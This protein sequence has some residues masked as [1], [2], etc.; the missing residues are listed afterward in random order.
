M[1]S[2][3]ARTFAALWRRARWVA[4]LA[5]LACGG[6]VGVAVA[7][8]PNASFTFSPSSPLT[9]EA[10][11]FDSN[12]TPDSSSRP[13]VREEWDLDNDGAFDDR[14]VC[15]PSAPNC[16]PT[17]GAAGAAIG[18]P[19]QHSYATPGSRTVR[20]RVIDSAGDDDTSSR[21]VTVRNR[22]PIASFTFS[23]QSGG[24]V[25]LTD[26]DVTF[27]SSGSSDPENGPIT[28]AW[29]FDGDG[30]DDGTA[31]VVTRRFATPGDKTVRLRVRDDNG[32]ETITSRTVTVNRRPTA[33][34]AFTPSNPETG[35]EVT[36]ESSGSS[37]PDG[38]LASR[39]WDLDND[40]QYDDASGVVVKHAFATPGDH[41][42]GLRVTDDRGGQDTTTRTIN[43]RNRPPV[44]SFTLEPTA[45]EAGQSITF[46]STSS[47]PDGTTRS[48]EWD[49]DGDGEFDDASGP[50]V[51]RS[52]GT[53]GAYPVSLRV[54]DDS[55]A[56]STIFDSIDVRAPASP[57]A[58]LPQVEA[59]RWLTPFP[60]VRI[61]GRAARNATLID[62]V[63]VQAPAGVQAVAR[64]RGRRCPFRSEV[65]AL[66]ARAG[67][68]GAS[69][70]GLIRFRK[71]SRARLRVGTVIEIYVTR[72]GV[73][74]KYT[75][76][77][78]R[79]SRPP[80]RLDQCMLPGARSPSACPSS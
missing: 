15:A 59:L 79:R 5:V 24:S 55:G 18:S 74:G 38:S 65:R 28:R 43:A 66:N 47:D 57:P 9:G 39:D 64:C 16:T 32:G 77:K 40:G 6:L 23:W 63:T 22:P 80:S 73:V 20:L 29:D 46:R 35:Q 4:A 44:A 54:T 33:A 51:V 60:I 11:T 12:S 70:V 61:R 49:L 75:R 72:A 76:F 78:I 31:T 19:F 67:G 7:D 69:G 58:A 37:D 3:G 45:P 1:G 17:P 48:H 27:D 62:F 10:I 2:K 71:L 42:V 25:P 52:F 36:L 30:F 53:A 8:E 50:E 21:T 34:F 56:S 14:R 26:E 68:A 41:T 13:I